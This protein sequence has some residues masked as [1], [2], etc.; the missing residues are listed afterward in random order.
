MLGAVGLIFADTFSTAVAGYVLATF[1]TFTCVFGN[2]F[3]DARRSEEPRYVP[4]RSVNLLSN[5]VLMAGIVVALPHIW[6]I[7]TDLAK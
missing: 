3:V 6:L 5:I 1:V 2:R 4:R 7:A